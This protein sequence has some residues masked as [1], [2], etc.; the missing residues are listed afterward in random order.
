MGK[1]GLSSITKMRFLDDFMID[2]KCRLEEDVCE[3]LTEI[4]EIGKFQSLIFNIK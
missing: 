2:Q 1:L 4:P 3:K